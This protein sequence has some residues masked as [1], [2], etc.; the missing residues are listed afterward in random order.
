MVRASETFPR[1][2][3][4]HRPAGQEPL[5]TLCEIIE[6]R[7]R[8]VFSFTKERIRGNGCAELVGSGVVLTGGMSLLRGCRDLA[9]SVFNGIPARI[10]RPQN[11]I[12]A[13]ETLSNPIY[14]TA[15]G[16]AKY[17]AEF[18]VRGEEIR[19]NQRHV[20]KAVFKKMQDWVKGRF[21][22]A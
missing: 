18:R 1:P 21:R 12:G 2:A 14:A 22:S 9:R 8:E 10:G 3:T 17:G 7:M 5:R 4:V 16:L 13:T 11:A 15:V 20:F 19:F 6:Y